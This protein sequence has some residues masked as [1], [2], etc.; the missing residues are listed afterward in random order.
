MTVSTTTARDSYTATNGQ[1]VFPYTFRILDD[2][3]LAVYVD[4]VLQTL[5]SDYTVSGVGDAGG[6]NVTF[7]SGLA[8]GESV[9]ILRDVPIEQQIDYTPFD[10][11]PAETHEQGLDYLTMVAQQLAEQFGRTLLLPPSSALTGIRLPVPGAGELLR[12]NA[13][14]TDLETV[15]VGSL[16][17]ALDTVLASLAANDMLVWDAGQSKWVNRAQVSSAERTAG[18]ET[19]IRSFAPADVKSMV[20]THAPSPTAPTTQVFTAGGTW[21]RPTGCRA[22]LVEVQGAG[23][24]GGGADQ[25]NSDGAGGGGGGYA[26]KLIDVSAISS[27]TITVGS[28]GSGGAAGGGNGTAGG[29][30]SWAD[31]TNT[32]TGNGGSA[33]NYNAVGGAGGGASGGDIHVTGSSGGG[34]VGGERCTGGGSYFGATTP[35]VLNLNR[36]D[37]TDGAGPGAGGSGALADGGGEG[38]GGDGADGLI[39]VTEFY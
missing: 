16:S 3:H 19:A 13:A 10:P 38:A 8:G 6:G 9:V 33:G 28:G 14:G 4:D 27:A 37:G 32:V 21:N 23:G 11:F 18:T 24:G 39:V 34:A 25:S 26:R 36:G 31:G 12:W 22:A 29:N 20:N 15:A 7:V 35:I 17:S 2:E 5:T 30:S 1:T